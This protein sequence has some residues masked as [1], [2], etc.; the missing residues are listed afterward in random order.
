MTSSPSQAVKLF[1]TE[2]PTPTAEIL[3]AGELSAELDAGNLRY[4]RY[5]GR[6]VIRAI[7]YVVRDRLWGTFGA[8]IEDLAID[9]REGGFTVTYR[10]RCRDESQSFAYEAR[11]AGSAEGRLSFEAV[12]VPET[13]FLTNRTGFV[14]LHGVEGIAGRPV[15]VLHVDGSRVQTRFPELIDPKQPIENIRALT[16]EVLPGLKAVCRM[17][18]EAFEMEDQRNWT[19]ASYKTYVRPLADPFPYTLPRGEPVEQSVTLSLEGS[20]AGGGAA[21]S[22]AAIRVTL[23]EASG[24]LPRFGMA[25]EAGHAEAALG[26][27][28]LLAPLRPAFLSLFFD[29]RSDGEPALRAAQSLSEALSTELAV[30]LVVPGEKD[31][32]SELAAF[33]DLLRSAGARPA[34][35][36][37]SPAGDMSFVMPGT[38]F[39]DTRDFD[40]LYAAARK[41]FPDL[42]LGGGNFVYFTELNRKRPPLEA[43]DFLCH[44]T[45]AIVHAADDRS[46]TETLE[47]LP[48]VIASGKELAGG[49]EYRVGPGS[50]GSRT[51]PFGGPTTP[52]PDNRRVT[53]TRN[54]PRQRSLLG[55]A[56]HL[57]YG[58]RMA[59][60]GVDSVILGAPIGPFGLVH[61]PMDWPQPWYDEAGGLYPAYHVMRALY[62][63][64]GAGLRQAESSSPRALQALAVESEAGLDLWLANLTGEHQEVEVAGLPG[65]RVSVCRLDELRFE[66]CAADPDAFDAEAEQA[67]PSRLS[68][69]PYAVL[70]LSSSKS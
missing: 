12:G 31:P 19:D 48:Y 35:L 66:A 33:A 10:A 8:E 61:H 60:G 15:E 1:G 38:V 58:A 17:E 51:S 28:G 37:V 4:I 59:A 25:L 29:A 63:A 40:R 49:K 6:E 16:H 65:P 23:G 68:L 30:E 46:L 27:L 39:P 64:S 42:R 54:D 22:D 53:M 3:V 44:P 20:A 24:R 13:D 2:E 32:G 34:S 67:D 45:S 50:L 36:A 52:N 5:R 14:V 57:G 62:A 7:S 69:R 21:A 56:W 47:S 11:I 26:K 18:G 55:A 70:R 41:H 9:R 43:L